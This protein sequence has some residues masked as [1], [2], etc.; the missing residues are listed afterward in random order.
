[1]EE[2]R[3]VNA[4]IHFNCGCTF[5]TNDRDEAMEHSQRTGHVLSVHGEIR[6][7]MVRVKERAKTEEAVKTK[8]EVET[9]EEVS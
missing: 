3:V 6:P 7:A 8:K 1:V 2:I 5:T 9:L 4:D